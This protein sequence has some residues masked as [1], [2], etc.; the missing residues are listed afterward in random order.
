M[1]LAAAPI[2]APAI[3]PTKP[4]AGV[5]VASPATTPVTMPTMLARLKRIHSISAQTRPALAAERWVAM[6]AA[7]ASPLAAS[8]EPALKPYQPTHSMPAP[9][10]V[11]PG[12]CGGDSS[13]G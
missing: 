3:G 5:T 7:A 1:R 8:A 12:L 2:A 9:I 13:F 10:I 4:D 6:R 11:R